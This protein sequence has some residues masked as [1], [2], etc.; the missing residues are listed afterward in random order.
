MKK[1]I[2]FICLSLLLA[3]CS[4]KQDAL[5]QRIDALTTGAPFAM[6]AI[7]LPQ[8]AQRSINL[9]ECPGTAP[10]GT[11]L[12]TEAIRQAIDEL[13]AQGGG[14]LVIPEG[15]WLTGPIELKSNVRLHTERG[16]LVLFSDDFGLYPIIETSFEGVNT[17]RCLSPL[18]AHDAENIAITG[19]GTF[20]GQG[21]AWRPVKKSKL[22]DGQ[23]KKKVQSGGVLSEDG[24]VWY[25]T[26]GARYAVS[27]CK[28]QN[29]PEDVKDE[30]EWEYIHAFLRPVMLSFRGCKNVLLEGVCFE[31]SPAWNLH[32]L[33]C[34]NVV[35]AD[36]SVRNPWY[37]QNGD[38]VD[39]ESCKNVVISGCTF[40]VGDDAICMKSG[41]NRD[42]RERGIAAENIVVDGC[43]VYHGHGGFV[44]G[45]EM[46]GGVKNVSVQHC[47]FEGTDVGL[48]FKSTRGRGG[49]VE[50]IYVK[51]IGMTDI[52]NEALLFD[53]FY[54]GKGAGEE[55]D[56][57]I[58]ARMGS[59]VPPVTE[60]TPAF[61]DI[62]IEDVV[63][64]GAKRPIYFNGLPEM[65]IRNVTLR[66][67]RMTGGDNSQFN[68]TENLVIED[69]EIN[70][71][72]IKN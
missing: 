12:C 31:N 63:C 36:L 32:P 57:E 58:A 2:F 44:V 8:F 56:E 62:V 40:D 41:K 65:P 13:N 6:P 49:V 45:S 15:I 48:R 3:S 68:R 54:G 42:G 4:C 38:G 20:N 7:Q 69:V 26:E 39:V 34:E 14:T 70:K 61:R 51:H 71:V 55:T 24:K 43:T 25:P 23:W 19:Q 29:V 52:P 33:M 66:H 5:Q 37:S 72:K 1:S 30:A 47:L 35:L 53:L 10:D 21:D 11:V 64:R 60:E 18:N 17:R 27:L 67:I 46:S 9:S 50:N 59:S 22:T 28:D 16:A